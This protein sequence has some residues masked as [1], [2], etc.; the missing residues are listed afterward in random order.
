[1][2]HFGIAYIA[3]NDQQPP[4]VYKI[5]GSSRDVVERMQELSNE[6]AAYGTFEAKA[7][8][9]VTDLERAESL[10]QFQLD[11][12]RDEKKIFKAPYN[13]ILEV[14]RGICEDFRPQPNVEK[15]R[16]TT[17]E[18]E[19]VRKPKPKYVHPKQTREDHDNRP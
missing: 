5:G 7:G 12:Y 9:P 11:E 3:Q 13:E 10:C 16:V 2:G 1:M 18:L 17:L 8:F 14:V 6:T 15:P 4:N 19:A